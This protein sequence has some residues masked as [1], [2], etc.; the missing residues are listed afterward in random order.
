MNESDPEGSA[1]FTV[2]RAGVA[3]DVTVYW[4]LGSEAALDFY[5]PLYGSLF[6]RSVITLSI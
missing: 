3:G 5:E 6:F 2:V 4:S 1:T